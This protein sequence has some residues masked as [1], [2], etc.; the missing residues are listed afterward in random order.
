MGYKCMTCSDLCVIDSLYHE[1][2]L[3]VY[4]DYGFLNVPAEI[5]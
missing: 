1:Y 3:N 4:L 2:F 5:K